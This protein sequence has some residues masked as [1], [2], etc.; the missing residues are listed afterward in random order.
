MA[1]GPVYGTII[2]TAIIGTVLL[3]IGRAWD[4]LGGT[5]NNLITSGFTMQQGVDTFNFIG[6]VLRAT[7]ILFILASVIN[8]IVESKRAK[9]RQV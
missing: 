2:N 6:L 9:N 4:L 7:G 1:I 8:I 5:M 3:A